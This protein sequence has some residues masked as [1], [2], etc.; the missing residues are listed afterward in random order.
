MRPSRNGSMAT[1][2]PSAPRRPW[3]PAQNFA[4]RPALFDRQRPARAVCSGAI[5]GEGARLE[6]VE[7]LDHPAGIGGR[8]LPAA[9]SNSTRIRTRAPRPGAG[10]LSRFPRE[11]R[12][13]MRGAGAS[14]LHSTGVAINSPS[15]SRSTISASTSEGRRPWTVSAL[16]PRAMA[17]SASRFLMMSLNSAL[18]SPLTP[19]A[20][21]T[22]RL[23][24]RARARSPLGAG[25]Q[26]M[27][28]ITSSREGSAAA[29]GSAALRFRGRKGG[30]GV[31]RGRRRELAQGRRGRRG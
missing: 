21:A 29:R 16:R 25:A 19:K 8:P 6:L 11:R 2:S 24:M 18:S 28:A 23:V 14:P 22:S 20:R 7:D 5:D 15:R 10:A 1:R 31:C 12:T 13:T 17:P 26:P 4:R 27:K 30:G 3:P 9:A